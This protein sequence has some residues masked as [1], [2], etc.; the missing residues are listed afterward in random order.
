MYVNDDSYGIYTLTGTQ[1]GIFSGLSFSFDNGS[2]GIYYAQYPDVVSPNGGGVAALKYS[3][4]FV[5]GVQFAGKFP[6]GEQEGR[7]VYFAFPFET[8][9]PEST[10]DIVMDRILSFFGIQPETPVR[11]NG[12][13]LY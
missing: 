12:C 8:I 1:E 9:Y 5:A 2:A 13:L 10:R 6:Q 11:V 4:S 7:M 3:G